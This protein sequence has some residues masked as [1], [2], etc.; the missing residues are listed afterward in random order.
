MPEELLQNL[1]F[2]ESEISL[3]IA[4]MQT[5]KATPARLSKLTGIHRTTI[6]SIAKSLKEKGVISEDLGGKTKYFVASPPEQLLRMIQ[7]EKRALKE[8]EE[9]AQKASDLFSEMS[10]SIEYSIPKI[11]F[12]EGEES[13]RRFLYEQVPTWKQE[14]SSER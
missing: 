6:Y 11:R 8:K 9:I 14:C 12:F 3:Y 7:K 1:G 13:V 10:G 2:N 4:L 5:K